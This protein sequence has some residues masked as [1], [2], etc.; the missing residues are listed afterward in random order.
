M[1]IQELLQQLITYLRGIWRYRWIAMVLVWGV[2]VTGWVVV[3]KMPDQY[4][5]TARIHVDTASLLRPL[6][7]DLAIRPNVGYRLKHMTRTLLSRPNLEKVV[8]M[9]DLDITAETPREMEMLLDGLARSVQ[10]GSTRRENLYTISYENKD[11]EVAKRVVQ[12]LLTIFME[13]TL[14]ETRADSDSAQRFLV[15]QIAD[16]EGLLRAAENRIK[17]FKRK[18]IGK[19]PSAGAGY[20]QRLQSAQGEVTQARLLLK[21]ATNR[22]DELR[23]QIEGEEPV[24]GFG[25]SSVAVQRSHPL[26]IRIQNL[27]SRLDE[28]YLQYTDQHPEVISAKNTIELLEKRKQEALEGAP[29]VAATP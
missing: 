29:V 27:R 5:A 6:L 19:M 11:G 16:H 1:P 9:T 12:A 17:E 14:G 20:F 4:K 8:R 15:Q 13:S 10:F 25:S 22:R 21:E 18:N 3:A 28:L 26:D 2:T 7:G 24:F 23:R